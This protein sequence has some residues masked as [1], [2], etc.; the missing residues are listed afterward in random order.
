SSAL[1]VW[2]AACGRAEIQL[3]VATTL[4]A[5][6]GTHLFATMAD[7]DDEARSLQEH[8]LRSLK[9][10]FVARM[11][12]LYMNYLL[13]TSISI[14]EGF[15]DRVPYHTSIL[16]GE[17]WILELLLGHPE[18]IRSELGMYRPVFEALVLKL[19]DLG[20]RDSRHVKLEEQVAIFLYMAVTGITAHHAVYF[21]KMLFIFSEPPFYANNVSL[22]SELDAT[23]SEIA[24][25]PR[26]MPYFQHIL[27]AL[28][29]SHFPWA[30]PA[31][32]HSLNR[33]R[34]G[35]LTQ[36]CLVACS[37]NLLFTY[38]TSGYEGS[39]SDAASFSMHVFTTFGF[40][41]ENVG[42]RMQ[43]LDHCRTED[44]VIIWWNGA[45]VSEDLFAK[46]NYSICDMPLH[47]MPL[48]ASL[49]FS[50]TVS[51]DIQARIPPALASIQNFIRRHGMS[52]R[53][54]ILEL[55]REI[56]AEIAALTMDQ[57]G[58][59]ADGPTSPAE[60]AEGDLRRDQIATA[61]WN[62]YLVII[63]A[64][65][66]MEARDDEVGQLSVPAE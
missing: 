2:R 56:E 49:V 64:R 47:E 4:P 43:D 18:R 65:G 35:Q 33:D 5:Y 20:H 32:E 62:D 14:A 17:A 50:K 8:R 31:A 13:N 41:K 6:L 61:M 58:D 15:Y 40:H 59:L 44:I 51:L 52:D 63:Q 42:L 16:T 38:F 46:R 30:P 23:P 28:D 66:L 10:L 54:T 29:G 24:D 53:E 19:R 12:Q 37:F 9:I 39:T 36:N 57:L 60:K 22:P 34:K 48:S 27:G 11:G 45:R 1:T 7:N 25:N 3:Q 21:K 26:F 55:Q